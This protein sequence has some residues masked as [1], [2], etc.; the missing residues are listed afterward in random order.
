MSENFWGASWV[1]VTGPC[2]H[3]TKPTQDSGTL[4]LG[5]D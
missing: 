5:M 1:G 3:L 4:G 2:E